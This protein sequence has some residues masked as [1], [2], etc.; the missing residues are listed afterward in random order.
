MLLSPLIF[1]ASSLVTAL[2]APLL[3]ESRPPPNAITASIP[4]AKR[5]RWHDFEEKIGLLHDGYGT[6]ERRS[7]TPVTVPIPHEKRESIKCKWDMYWAFRG[8]DEEKMRSTEETC[9]P[10]PP[11]NP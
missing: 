5:G 3:V 11:N 9:L 7:L 8:N 4:H 2:A 6:K 1:I 10:H